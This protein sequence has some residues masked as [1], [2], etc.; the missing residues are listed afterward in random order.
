MA[1]GA[2]PVIRDSSK[3]LAQ[4]AGIRLGVLG[5][6]FDP[7]HHG[8]LVAASVAHHQLGLDKVLFVPAGN[9]PH[10]PDRPITAADHRLRMIELAIAG[11]SHFAVSR[12][13][14]D[15]PG[16]CYTVDTLR[17]LRDEWGS[18]TALFFVEGTD[19]L[20]E[21]VTW[22]QPQNLL[23]LGELAVVKRP[24]VVVDLAALEREL[25][26][27][28]S[29]LH[30]LRM[31]GLEISSSDLRA[32]VREGRPISYLVPLLVERYILDQGLYLP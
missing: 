4:L 31:P 20:A 24:G 25:P 16:P 3:P 9:P 2:S 6:T 19:S 22:Y 14:L 18:D 17:L 10:K 21:M 30:W 28:S 23:E 8:H 15:R 27:I 12:L 5:G 29:R 32:R 26:G 1:A 11:R 7:I 13:D